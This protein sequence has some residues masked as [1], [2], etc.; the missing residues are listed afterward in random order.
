MKPQIPEASNLSPSTYFFPLS[1]TIAE[2]MSRAR[3]TR[4][5]PTIPRIGCLSTA[6]SFSNRWTMRRKMC[7]T[8]KMNAAVATKI[9]NSYSG[10]KLPGQLDKITNVRKV[11]TAS[12]SL[13]HPS[14]VVTIHRTSQQ[15]QLH[16]R[17]DSVVVVASSSAIFAKAHTKTGGALKP[18]STRWIV[19]GYTRGEGEVGSSGRS[20]GLSRKTFR[21]RVTKNV[22]ASHALREPITY[23][24]EYL[25][26]S[27]ASLILHCCSN[28]R[29]RK[30]LHLL[31][32]KKNWRTQKKDTCQA[33]L[34]FKHRTLKHRTLNLFYFLKT[35]LNAC[36]NFL[37][38]YSHRTCV[39][40]TFKKSCFV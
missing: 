17:C 10:L 7:K 24:R 5:R 9:K 22:S 6:G 34:D 27:L 15:L 35:K 16:L 13:S 1:K 12:T 21:S 33:A 14:I 8:T 38:F 40:F 19:Q 11:M 18:L 4:K 29:Q 3:A 32:Q 39:I 37:I 26:T 25:C 36:L 28:N 2:P 30:T 31:L 20:L 23:L